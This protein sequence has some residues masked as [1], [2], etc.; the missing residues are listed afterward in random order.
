MDLYMLGMDL[1]E[2]SE[3]SEL[4]KAYAKRTPKWARKILWHELRT[5]LKILKT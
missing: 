3:P 5:T 2:Q 4:G 1:I